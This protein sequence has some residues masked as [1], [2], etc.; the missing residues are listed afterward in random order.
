MASVS[1]VPETENLP[2]LNASAGIQ[3]I[4]TGNPGYSLTTEKNFVTNGGSL[5]F[6][7]GEGWRSNEAV[8][9]TVGG[10]K[11]SW[12]TGYTLGIQNDG[13]QSNPFVTYS[14]GL[15][16]YGLYLVGGRNVAYLVG[17]RF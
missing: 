6:Y 12:K 5:N 14:Q 9:R 10:M 4:G 16:T 13:I 1:L 7:I 15:N 8:G 3:G 17:T 11:F 2:A